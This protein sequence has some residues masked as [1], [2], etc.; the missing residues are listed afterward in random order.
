VSV[1]CE[2]LYSARPKTGLSNRIISVNSNVDGLENGEVVLATGIDDGTDS[3]EE[4][5][6]PLGKEAVGDFAE[7]G[8]W[9]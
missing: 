8:T 7:N 3:G 1:F 2:T 6:A 9:T 4:E 5:A